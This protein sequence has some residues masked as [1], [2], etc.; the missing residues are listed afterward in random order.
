MDSNGRGAIITGKSINTA[1]V[2]PKTSLSSSDYHYSGSNDSEWRKGAL[3]NFGLNA[4]DT[5]IEM[6][7]GAT[8]KGELSSVSPKCGNFL[9]FALEAVWN[10]FPRDWH[11]PMMRSDD[12]EWGKIDPR[13]TDRVCG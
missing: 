9:M 10:I 3:A 13:N 6:L 5:R 11:L 2:G 8:L 1:T 7:N 12:S 4:G